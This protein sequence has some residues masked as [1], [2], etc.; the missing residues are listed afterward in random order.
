MGTKKTDGFTIIEVMLVL[1]ITGL[2]L[3]GV[4]VGTSAQITRQ[5]YRSSVTALQ[6]ELQRQYS[7]VQ[8][9]ENDRNDSTVNGCNGSR[10]ASSTCFLLGRF[11]VGNS[12]KLTEYSVIGHTASD[13]SSPITLPLSDSSPWSLHLDEASQEE[14]LVQWGSKINIDTTNDSTF[15]FLILMAP[16]TGD[17]VTYSDIGHAADTDNVALLRDI[18]ANTAP[19]RTVNLCVTGGGSASIGQSLA[20]RVASGASGSASISIPS[21][22]EGVCA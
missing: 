17:I 10:G 7:I 18:V 22:N 15:A 4:L 6:S 16:D 2:M 13:S 1:A 14:Y 11:V 20:V 21:Q 5:E 9:P 12:T 8:N 3:V 19:R